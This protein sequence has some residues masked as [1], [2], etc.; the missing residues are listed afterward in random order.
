MNPRAIRASLTVAAV[1]AF[2]LIFAQFSFV[3]LMRRHGVSHA[4]ETTFLGMMAITANYWPRKIA[5]SC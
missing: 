5:I 2:F 4:G 3:E 1:Y